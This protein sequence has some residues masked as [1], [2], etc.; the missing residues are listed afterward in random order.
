[1]PDLIKMRKTLLAAEK[2]VKGKKARLNVALF[3]PNSY[4]VAVSS[5]SFHRIWELTNRV[6]DTGVSRYSLEGKGEQ[7]IL[8]LDTELDTSDIDIIAFFLSYEMDYFNVVKA[9]KLL[10]IPLDANER[11]GYPLIIGGGIAL[12]QNPEPVADIFDVIFIGEAEESYPAF[13]K[14]FFQ[15]ESKEEILDR[16]KMIDGVYIPSK[17]SFEYNSDGTISNII[18]GKI[19][20]TSHKNFSK[21]FARSIFIT[22]KGEFSN[23][24]LI[25]LTRGCPAH[26]R[27]CISRTLYAPV[28]FSDKNAVMDLIDESSDAG[29]FGLLGA[30]VSFHPD[31]KEVMSFILSKDKTFSISSLR[32]E[33]LDKEFVS[34]LK[35]GGT[36]TM[37]IA[38]EAGSETLRNRI[39]KGIT[40]EHIE[41]AVSL[42]LQEAMEGLKLYF[43]IGLPGETWEDIEAIIK[44]SGLIRRTENTS[45]KKF[46]KISFTISPFIPKPFTP[47]QWSVFEGV[48]GISK[49]INYLRKKL[50]GDGIAVLYDQP[51]SAYVQ[52]VLSRGDR[53]LR[54]FLDKG[55]D[56]KDFR[57]LNINPSFYAERERGEDEIFPWNIIDAR[58]I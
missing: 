44:M 57:S 49:K 48:G 17:Y 52:A 2:G 41:N 21:D 30:S 13:L 28:R 22:D 31:I 11:N 14:L 16:A 7:F 32:A 53:K 12:T 39:C 45:R 42:A 10:N 3:Y 35:R 40:D 29:R 47:L 37:T 25:E 38:P 26:C 24:F 33:R 9:L 19:K 34:L 18:G 43:M 55:G 6:D 1:M 56:R 46:R 4:H 15:Y 58:H 27:F 54:Y 51:K 8:P 5:L 23:T 50:V 20:K 36:K